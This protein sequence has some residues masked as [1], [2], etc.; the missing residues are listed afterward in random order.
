[1]ASYNSILRHVSMADVKRNTWKL[2]E[3]KRIEE[4][5]HKEELKILANK[6][7]PDY[8]DWRFDLSENMTTQSM[9]YATTLPAEGDTTLAD[10]TATEY[11]LDTGASVDGNIMVLDSNN[12]PGSFGNAKAETGL[13]DISNF[14]TLKF[15]ITKRSVGSSEELRLFYRTREMREG[16][17]NN[18][19]IMRNDFFN[20]QTIDL[21][22]SKDAV[23]TE[24]EFQIRSFFSGSTTP[25][26]YTTWNVNSMVFQRR[27]PLTVFVPLD[28][29]E[30]SSFVRTGEFSQ[31]S[32]EQKID[33]LRK[34]MNAS[35]Q[36]LQNK[37]GDAFP[38][39][40]ADQEFADVSQAPSWEQAAGEQPEPSA[41][42]SP[43][44]KSSVP[45]LYKNRS[46][47]WL[48]GAIVSGAEKGDF[49]DNQFRGTTVRVGFLKAQAKEL[50]R[51]NK[52]IARLGSNPNFNDNQ[53]QQLI[54]LR[55]NTQEMIK[56]EI[57]GS[58]PDLKPITQVPK[59]SDNKAEIEK[60]IQASLKQLEIDNEQLK[61][62]SLKRNLSFAVDLGLDI[63][64]V[65]TLL[66]PIPGDEAA[67]ISAQAAKQGVKTASKQTASAA[68]KKALTDPN[69]AK[70]IQQAVDDG[71]MTL[72]DLI[73]LP[74]QPKGQLPHSVP[75]NIKNNLRMDVQSYQPTGDLIVE[76][77]LKNPKAFFQDKDIK[78]EFPENPPPPQIKGLHPDLVTGEKTSQRFNKLDPISAKAMPRTGIKA[79]DKKV[80]KAK[81]LPK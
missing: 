42:S 17:P 12:I 34:M 74:I 66:S 33:R 30:A 81:R 47:A 54:D 22:Y 21:T 79:I 49:L 55:N 25:R 80:E 28:S 76:K 62:E 10:V 20:N 59:T 43:E 15:N 3:Q 31:L 6:N 16:G 44:T 38:G 26:D 53:M 1:M 73:N 39:T 24:L 46:A 77:K 45:N 67:V 78:P 40:N 35:D 41:D 9:T 69:K 8:S 75:N 52:K 71:Y 2:Q 58:T 4:L 57:D 68:V 64:T 27:T 61:G 32:N 72:D 48:G 50:S 51:L 14:T 37:F 11:I 60:N 18:W 63:L 65:I 7:S 36:Y 19:Y 56:A 70:K 29:P 23:G 5:C 13:I